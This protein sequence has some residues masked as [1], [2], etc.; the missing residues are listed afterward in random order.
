LLV[1]TYLIEAGVLLVL[2]PWTASWDRNYFGHLVP[3]LG[4][5]M[6]NAFVRGGVS[7][8]GLIT[9]VAGFLD[10][11]GALVARHH[12]GAGPSGPVGSSSPAPPGGPRA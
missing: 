9:A 5:A 11:A 1:A 12:A 6:R 3:W 8:L 4:V 10:L 7:G 2:A